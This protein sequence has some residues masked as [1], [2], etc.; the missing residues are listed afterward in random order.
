MSVVSP[1]ARLRSPLAAAVVLLAF[2]VGTP[3]HA[4]SSRS[5]FTIAGTSAK[6]LRMCGAAHQ[7]LSTISGSRLVVTIRHLARTTRS[8]TVARC[9]AGTWHRYRTVH[10]SSRRGRLPRLPAGRYRISGRGVAT[11]YLRVSGA[12]GAP[13]YPL[14]DTS[15]VRSPMVAF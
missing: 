1:S 7:T 15:A 10:V 13:E 3:A 4:A 8:L 2:A 14:L 11:G 6:R 9:R 12:G 5:P